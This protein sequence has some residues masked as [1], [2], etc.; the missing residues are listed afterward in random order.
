MDAVAHEAIAEPLTARGRSQ[1]QVARISDFG[2]FSAQGDPVEDDREHADDPLG[3]GDE[4]AVGVALEAGVAEEVGA[5]VDPIGEGLAADGLA[6]EEVGQ[7]LRVWGAGRLDG[8]FGEGVGQ[9]N[10]RLV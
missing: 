10:L 1:A 2:G 7:L 8:K 9:G 4:D 6:R 3:G 5:A